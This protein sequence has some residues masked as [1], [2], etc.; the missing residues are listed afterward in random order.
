MK[1]ILLTLCVILL[2][3]LATLSASAQVKLT[4]TVT[5]A[6]GKPLPSITVQ[7]KGSNA[8]TSTNADGVYTL[9]RAINPGNYTLVFSGVGFKTEEKPFTVGASASYTI[10]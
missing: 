2:A 1:K 9:S 6:T 10:D 8:G 5:D 7:L 3:C 4:G